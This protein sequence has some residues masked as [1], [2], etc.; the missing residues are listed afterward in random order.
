VAAVRLLALKAYPSGFMGFI[1]AAESYR[2]FRVDRRGGI[3][4]L[5]QYPRADFSSY[6]HFVGMLSR[7]VSTGR[8]LRKPLFVR[9]LTAAELER[10]QQ[11]IAIELKHEDFY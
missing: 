11:R 3:H 2:L 5:N 9:A 6:E 8:F 4:F 1:E 10:L 7:F